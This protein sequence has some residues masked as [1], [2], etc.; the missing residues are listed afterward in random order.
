MSTL[1]GMRLVPI[2]VLLVV[3]AG[4]GAEES[5]EDEVRPKRPTTA[6]RGAAVTR[7]VQV[8]REPRARL[9]F[10]VDEGDHQTVE[11]RM[12]MDMDISVDGQRQ[13]VPDIP[14]MIMRVRTDIA[15]IADDGVITTEFEYTDTDVDAEGAQ[16]DAMRKGLAQLEGVTG[17]VRGTATGELVSSDLALPDGMDAGVRT[18]LEGMEEQLGNMVVPLPREPLGE[19]GVWTATTKPK[20]NGIESRIESRYEIR[21]R[22][23]DVLTLAVSYRQTAP[24]QEVDLPGMPAGVSTHVDSME[25]TGRGETVLDLR[26]MLPVRS[27]SVADGP[28]RMTLEKDGERAAMRQRMHLVLTM[29]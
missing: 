2:A 10:D 16:A 9:R 6:Q 25:I 11:M 22:E 17:T 4:C 13:Q 7:L 1:R 27:R 18:M 29:R 21:K 19:G 28:I 8:G 26:R 24:A 20:L 15:D 12:D 3:A 14:P 23:G 5:H